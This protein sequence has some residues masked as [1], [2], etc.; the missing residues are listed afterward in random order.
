MLCPLDNTLIIMVRSSE[1][2]IDEFSS[3]R[4]EWVVSCLSQ[5]YYLTGSS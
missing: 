5:L 3:G 1:A 4:P 2:D